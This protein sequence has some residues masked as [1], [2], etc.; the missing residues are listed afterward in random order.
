LTIA[1][2]TAL[3]FRDLTEALMPPLI[4]GCLGEQERSNRS[5]PGDSFML[6][7]IAGNSLMS[8]GCGN[9]AI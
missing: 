3:P 4:S 8:A 5:L 2:P 1:D 7:E 9:E 6:A